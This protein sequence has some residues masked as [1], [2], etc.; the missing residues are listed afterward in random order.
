[1]FSPFY[2]LFAPIFL[3]FGGGMLALYVRITHDPDCHLQKK[4]KSD[5]QEAQELDQDEH[6]QQAG[7]GS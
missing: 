5:L 2:I 6:T 1:M 7:S 3:I 4:I